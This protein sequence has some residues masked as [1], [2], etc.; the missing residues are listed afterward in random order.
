M[1]NYHSKLLLSK[2][3]QEAESS[4][5][6]SG[7]DS[8]SAV[9]FRKAKGEFLGGLSRH[10]SGRLGLALNLFGSLQVDRIELRRL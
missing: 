2:S 8:S 3:L 9:V 4:W 5:V 10:G 1:W 6:G 7:E